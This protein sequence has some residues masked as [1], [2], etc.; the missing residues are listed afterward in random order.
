[1]LDDAD[2]RRGVLGAHLKLA[3]VPL[4]MPDSPDD[5]AKWAIDQDKYL[6]DLA[7]RCGGGLPPETWL[8][9]FDQWVREGHITA[10]KLGQLSGSSSVQTS[11]ALIR[12]RAIGDFESQWIQGFYNDLRD[13]RYIGADGAVSDSQIYYR[14]RLYLGKMRGTAGYGFVDASTSTDSFDWEMTGL[15]D[16]CADC[17]ILAAGGPYTQD[18][19]YTTPG[20]CDTPCLGYCKCILRRHSDG[21]TSAMPFEFAA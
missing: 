5:F 13:G 4:Q 16:H 19:L 1:M 12:G 10:H 17:P 20:A 15:E 9:E 21:A 18:T 11:L 3:A 14:M 6:R 8:H 7:S 2:W